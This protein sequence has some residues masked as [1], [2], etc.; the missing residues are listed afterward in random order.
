MVRIKTD[1]QH[2]NAKQVI[3]GLT[4]I[5]LFPNWAMGFMEIN[6]FKV[7]PLDLHD[8]VGGKK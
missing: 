4:T 7:L 2:L 3:A 5:R 6:N 1:R 8:Q